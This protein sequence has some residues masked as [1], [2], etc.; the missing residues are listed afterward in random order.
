MILRP[1]SRPLAWVALAAAAAGSSNCAGGRSSRRRPLRASTEFFEA[2]VRPVLAANCYDCHTEEAAR[3]A[4]ARLARGDAQGRQVGPRDR[5]GDPDKSLL[6]QAVRQ[7]GDTLKMPK[8]GR[9]K[10]DEVDALVEWVRAGAVWPDGDRDRGRRRLAR[11]RRRTRS[12]RSSARSGR[13]S[14]SASRRSRPSRTATGRRPTSIASCSRASRRRAWRP[15][16]AAD[17]RTLIRRATLDLTGLPPT[18][19]E[20]DAFQK[21]DVARRV[22]E[23]RRPAARVAAVRRDVG[24]DVARRRALRRRRLPIARSDGPRLQPVSERVSV[25]RLG[26][27]GVQRRPAVRPVRARAARRP[28]CSATKRRA[29]ARCRRSGSSAWVR[30][31]T[32]TARSKSRAPTSATI[33]WTSSRAASSG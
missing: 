29:R 21:D 23:G 1:T 6:I 5:A 7:T 3:R 15:S 33:A 13:S 14:R 30:G 20:I 17:K 12:H 18:P 28:I 19:E 11:Q 27:Q 2:K 22:R 32:T 16:R 4:A 31:S 10:P 9:L 25:S 8:G 24:P 26:D